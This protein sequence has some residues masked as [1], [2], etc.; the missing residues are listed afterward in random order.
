MHLPLR[1]VA[2]IVGKNLHIARQNYQLS[3]GGF[4]QRFQTLFLF[5]LGVFGHRRV[6]EGIALKIQMRISLFFM[7]CDNPHDVHG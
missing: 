4:Y 3:S 1:Y 7:I 2:E 5:R 6:V